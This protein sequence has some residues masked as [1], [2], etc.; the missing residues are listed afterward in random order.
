MYQG[1][2]LRLCAVAQATMHACFSLTQQGRSS[3]FKGVI[4]RTTKSGRLLAL[5]LAS[6]LAASLPVR[7]LGEPADV[8]RV[9]G[10]FVQPGSGFI[11]GQ[12]LYV[13]GGASVGSLNL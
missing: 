10:F 2:S 6:L 4:M 11:T 12:V 3:R 13:C 5:S 7:R 1:E 8:A 9:A